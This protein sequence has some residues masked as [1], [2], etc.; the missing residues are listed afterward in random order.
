MICQTVHYAGHVQGVGFRYRTCNIAR[1]YDVAGYVQNL[2]DGRV[3]LVAEGDSN[4][5]NDFLAEVE[6]ELRRHIRTQTRE[7]SPAT[8]NYVT[9]TIQR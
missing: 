6:L 8:G 9:F 4:V 7:S 5:V 1:R 2:P 3:R